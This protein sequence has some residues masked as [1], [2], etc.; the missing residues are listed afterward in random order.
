[1]APEELP[2]ACDHHKELL[3]RVGSWQTGSRKD[4]KKEG[5]DRKDPNILAVFL[6]FLPHLSLR[7]RQTES[8]NGRQ[9]PSDMNIY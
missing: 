9:L 8:G 6:T 5:L 7:N 4:G 1:M 3:P 2:Q